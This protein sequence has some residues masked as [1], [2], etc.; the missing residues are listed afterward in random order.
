MRNYD[1]IWAKLE[2]AN[3]RSWRLY[4]GKQTSRR[5]R[6]EKKHACDTNRWFCKVPE[7]ELRQ[8]CR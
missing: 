6:R 4:E 2:A 7:S 8:I 5:R 1:K 3:R